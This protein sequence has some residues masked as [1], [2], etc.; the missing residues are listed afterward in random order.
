MINTWALHHDRDFWGGPEKFRPGRFM[1]DGGELLP[2]SHPNI[3]HVLPFGAC[4]R[5]CLGQTFA[6]TRLF[7]WTLVKEFVITAAEGS[8]PD[9]MNPYRQTDDGIVLTPLPCH[10]V[11]TPTNPLS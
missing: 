8:D 5:V 11:F 7:L 2:P 3:K 1:D 4:P 6:M 10:V 9:W